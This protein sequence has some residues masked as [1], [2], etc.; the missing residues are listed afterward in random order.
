MY[1]Y[2]YLYVFAYAYVYAYVCVY[3]YKYTGFIYIEL[4]ICWTNS[5][6]FFKVSFNAFTAQNDP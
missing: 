6:R 2:V 5:V 3:I 1:L 4:A